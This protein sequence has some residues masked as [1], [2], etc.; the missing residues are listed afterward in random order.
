LARRNKRTG[1][2]KPFD[3]L[4]ERDFLRGRDKDAFAAGAAYFLGELNAIHE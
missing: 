1:L 4:A 2:A 3:G